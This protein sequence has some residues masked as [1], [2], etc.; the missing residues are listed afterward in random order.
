[1]TEEERN[2]ML[3]AFERCY[4]PDIV[5]MKDL[6]REEGDYMRRQPRVDPKKMTYNFEQYWRYTNIL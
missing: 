1:M 5:E 6:V 3:R 2:H 4:E